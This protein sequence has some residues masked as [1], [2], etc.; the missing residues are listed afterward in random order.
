M[1]WR[2]SGGN[3]VYNTLRESLSLLQNLGKSNVLESAIPMGIISAPHQ[4]DIWLES[5]A[6]LRW[7]NLSIGYR[8]DVTSIKFISSLRVSANANNLALIT[9]YKGL[10]P[11]VDVNGDN[12]S[13]GDNGI[14]PKTRTFSLGLNVSFK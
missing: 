8:F 3:K 9:K 1:V 12:G 4:S 13:G 2:G 5:G 10:D 14:Y 7:Q 6:F 11:E